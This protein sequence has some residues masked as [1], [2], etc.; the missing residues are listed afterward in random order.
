MT[1]RSVNPFFCYHTYRTKHTVSS[2]P[3]KAQ[4]KSE[5]SLKV[6]DLKEQE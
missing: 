6:I 4:P 1:K 3:L 2:V 5:A